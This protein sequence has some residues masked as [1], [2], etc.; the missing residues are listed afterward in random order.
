MD[1]YG[2]TEQEENAFEMKLK[3]TNNLSRYYYSRLEIDIRV[4]KDKT[5]IRRSVY[6]IF[7]LLG[8]IGG[9][10]GLFV[11]I[12]TTLLSII[13]FQKPENILASNLFFSMKGVKKVSD[14]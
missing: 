10:Y 7:A 2:I 5:I 1:I 3:Q 4:N 6:N 14:L 8:D 13:N 11:S 9:F 12:A